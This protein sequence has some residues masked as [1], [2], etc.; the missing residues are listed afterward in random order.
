[1]EKIQNMSEA[2]LNFAVEYAAAHNVE[3]NDVL[4]SLAHT[5]SIYGF[6]VK[7]DDVDGEVLKA[8]LIGCLAASCDHLI[9]VNDDEEA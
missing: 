4:N 7:R 6:S 9:E 8:G 5:Y 1:M 2:L 3:N